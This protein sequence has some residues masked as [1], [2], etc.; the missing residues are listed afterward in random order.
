MTSFSPWSLAGICGNLK[1]IKKTHDI[2]CNVIFIYIY[3]HL[4]CTIF[5]SYVHF[6][7]VISNIP[8][9]QLKLFNIKCPTLII[10]CHCLSYE[11]RSTSFNVIELTIANCKIILPA[12]RAVGFKNVDSKNVYSTSARNKDVQK[13]F[14]RAQSMTSAQRPWTS[15]RVGF[16]CRPVGFRKIYRPDRKHTDPGPVD[17]WFCR[18]LNTYVAETFYEEVLMMKTSLWRR[19]TSWHI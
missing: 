3:V 2:I 17:Q 18:S 5:I 12:L 1:H 10:R 7:W 4:V 15:C 8:L 14:I 6:W 9:D 19:A 11:S 16:D 13:T